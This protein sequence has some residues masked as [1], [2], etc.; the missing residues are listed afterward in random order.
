MPPFFL[1]FPILLLSSFDS[2]HIILLLSPSFDYCAILLLRHIR[3][4]FICL[5]WFPRHISPHFRA[6]PP[7]DILSSPYIHFAIIHSSSF[8][9]PLPYILRSFPAFLYSLFFL[10]L[11]FCLIISLPARVHSPSPFHYSACPLIEAIAF[12][13]IHRLI[14]DSFIHSFFLPFIA[15]F[16]SPLLLHARFIFHHMPDYSYAFMLPPS[17]IL[18]FSLYFIYYYIFIL[19]LLLHSV[20]FALHIISLLA[21]AIIFAFHFHYIIILSFLWIFQTFIISVVIEA[22]HFIHIYIVIS[23][24]LSFLH[25]LLPY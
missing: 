13:M 15:F 9:R 22:L 3:Y 24:F 1:Y 10:S 21:H 4:Y 12:S 16:L 17:A 14:A 6:L 7:A 8:L 18:Y 25:M 19:L 2:F 5:H 23:C 20:T 11:A